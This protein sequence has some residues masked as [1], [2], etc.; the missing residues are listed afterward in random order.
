[1]PP[2]GRQNPLRCCSCRSARVKKLSLVY[3][4]GTSHTQNV[5]AAFYRG[6]SRRAFFAS[7]GTR[8]TLLARSA[9]PPKKKSIAIPSIIWIVCALLLAVILQSTFATICI[10]LVASAGLTLQFRFA[11]RYNRANWPALY[12]TWN[13]SFLC[14]ECGTVTVFR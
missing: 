10:F 11:T 12:Q 2:T 14:G 4:Q 7:S 1:M 13:K 9:A 8:Q 6:L 5:G 3:L